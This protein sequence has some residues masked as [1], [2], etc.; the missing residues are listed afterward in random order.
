MA[1]FDNNSLYTFFDLSTKTVNQK[2]VDEFLAEKYPVRILSLFWDVCHMGSDAWTHIRFI[3]DQASQ[4]ARVIVLLADWL[5][6]KSEVDLSGL[7]IEVHYI[8]GIGLTAY[9][10]VMYLQKCQH[11]LTY[12]P[13]NNFLFLTGKW[14][15]TNRFTLFKKLLERGLLNDAIYSLYLPEDHEYHK[16]NSNPDNVDTRLANHT[17][18]IPFDHTIYERTGFRLISETEYDTDLGHLYENGSDP[19][20]TEKTWI[21]M[22]NKH[23]FI[24]AGQVGTLKKLQDMGYKTFEEYLPHKYDD[25]DDQ[26]RLDLIV[27]NV[28]YWTEHLKENPNIVYDVEHNFRHFVYRAE[29][30]LS[31]ISSIIDRYNLQCNVRDVLTSRF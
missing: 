9:H 3:L 20:I 17:S 16:Y 31:V 5:Q 18:A 1:S 15:K 30:D 26:T 2:A 8:N 12:K 24:M 6:D 28:K 10:D 11:N 13:Q 22:I 23:P 14:N 19:W 21:T 25:S 4:K 27:D 7:D 29:V